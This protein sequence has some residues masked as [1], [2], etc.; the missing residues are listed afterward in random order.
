MSRFHTI[1]QSI[2]LLCCLTPCL[3]QAQTPGSLIRGHLNGSY[4]GL[5]QYYLRDAHIGAVVPQDR[6]GT[7]S[8]LKLDYTH[9]SFSG[10]LQFESYLPPILGFYPV[11]VKAGNKIVNRYVRYADDKFSITAGDFY[12]QFGSGLILR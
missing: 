3:S 2:L 9:G 1:F 6:F 5:A 11:P 8:F 12:E 4:E 7:N 10:G